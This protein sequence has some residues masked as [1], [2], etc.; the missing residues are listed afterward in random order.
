[1][2]FVALCYG[3]FESVMTVIY[4]GNRRKSRFRLLS[5]SVMGVFFL[6]SLILFVDH[7]I[8][9]KWTGFYGIKALI[10][11]F[12][13]FTALASVVAVE[14]GLSVTQKNYLK[15]AF[16][17]FVDPVLVDQIMVQRKVIVPERREISVMFSDI[18][19]FTE[20]CE[21]VPA[22]DVLEMLKEYRAV[23]VKT[24]KDHGGYID[25]FVGDAIMAFWGA[26]QAHG[27]H[28]TQAVFAALAMRK[29]LDRLNQKRRASGLFEIE[30]GVGI[31]QGEAIVG[32]IDGEEKTEYTAL[33]QSVNL[34]ARV[35]GFTKELQ[36]DILLSDELYHSVKS[37]VVVERFENVQLKG[38]DNPVK[39]FKLIGAFEDGALVCHYSPWQSRFDV[40]K[41]PGIV[42][43]AGGNL[44]KLS[45]R[46][47]PKQVA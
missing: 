32:E 44:R 29:E 8:G 33:G 30:M 6:C 28:T 10:F 11:D 7:Y 15:G 18:R 40:V 26:P 25:K 16:G 3:S 19:S 1:M 41:A 39:L 21:V 35:E 9:S 36:T 37:H 24:I 27:D 43:E 12:I 38:I 20:I 14:F 45:Y 2:R 5:C 46:D 23:M 42:S 47:K 17:R 13:L 31:A 34:A 22:V 4:L